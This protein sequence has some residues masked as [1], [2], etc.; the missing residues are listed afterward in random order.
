MSDQVDIKEMPDQAK[1]IF[2]CTGKP[3]GKMRNELTVDM[4]S[5]LKETFELAT[6]EGSF[7]G[8]DAT[9]PP[10]LALFIASITGCIMTQ[11]RAFSKRMKIEVSDLNIKTKFTWNWKKVEDIY[12]TS[13]EKF[14]MNIYIDSPESIE[15]VKALIQ[16][17]KKGCFI[18]QTLSQKNTIN[19]KLKSQ[20]KWLDI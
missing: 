16:A 13:P 14:E 8:G 10:P 7:H 5:P 1:V 9:A 17:S 15:K 11:I 3:V 19:H 4:V 12:E 6:D 20:N 18:E 2:E